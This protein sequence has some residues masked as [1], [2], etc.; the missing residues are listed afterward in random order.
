MVRGLARFKDHFQRYEDHYVL[1]GGTASSLAME[2]AGLQFRA[3]IDLDIV[4][5]V[6][7]LDADF[8]RTFWDF[9]RLG[10]YQN[11]Q[12]STG[13]R[14]FYRFSGPED[15]SFPE[16]LELFS[17]L[18]DA[19]AYEGEGHLTPI[20]MGEE[21]SSLS[22]ILLDDSYYAFLHAGKQDLDG[23][24]VLIPEYI[25]PLKA[26]AWLDLSARREG[27]ERCLS[28]HLKKHKLDVFRLFQVISADTRIE[29]PGVV[30]VDMENFFTKMASESIDLRQ[31][32]YRRGSL[33]EVLE[34]LRNIYGLTK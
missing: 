26:R 24:S 16:M 14:Q 2:E 15:Q 25:I 9:I 5:C 1:I 4:L 11:R 21:A 13:E 28:K 19:L 7:A 23:L 22:A 30:G 32:G 6:E 20:P 33:L 12:K 3:T 31:L 34:G 18:P 17:R 8:V 29:V 27:G 10:N